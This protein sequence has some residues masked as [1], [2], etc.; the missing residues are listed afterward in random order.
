MAPA[1]VSKDTKIVFNN[2]YKLKVPRTVSFKHSE[3]DKVRISK[4]CSVFRKGYE[5][6]FTDEFFTI[7]ERIARDPPVYKLV[8]CTGEP[9]KGT[10]YEPELQLVFVDKNKVLKYRK[11]WLE[12]KSGSL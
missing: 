9:V 4:L 11:Y 10:F 7:T 6:T 5:Q 12:K 1:D 8:D 3:G 2:L